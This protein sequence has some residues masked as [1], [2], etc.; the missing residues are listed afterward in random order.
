M[1]LLS[2]VIVI[3]A[4]EFHE[5]AAVVGGA[6]VS[7]IS[8]VVIGASKFHNSNATDNGGALYSEHS[9]ITL[10]TCEFHGNTGNL[11]SVL[12]SSNKALLQLK[13]VN[14]IVTVLLIVEEYCFPTLVLSQ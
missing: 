6:L 11:G 2:S 8:T 7:L 5:N 13:Q 3:N 1:Y 14:L 10:D 12:M 4:S 9:S